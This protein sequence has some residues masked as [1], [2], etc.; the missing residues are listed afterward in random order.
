MR[1]RLKLVHSSRKI[2][3]EPYQSIATDGIGVAPFFG[4]LL[5]CCGS[6]RVVTL[7]CHL[8]YFRLE[9]PNFFHH[10]FDT[11]QTHHRSTQSNGTPS[12]ITS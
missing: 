7:G 4:E 6:I 8:I 3:F 5:H 1:S 10:S 11:D 2:G 9:D 12:F